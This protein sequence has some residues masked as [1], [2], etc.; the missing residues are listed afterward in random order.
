MQ[1]HLN[2]VLLTTVFT[3][4]LEPHWPSAAISA[5]GKPLTIS[6][7]NDDHPVDELSVTQRHALLEWRRQ[8]ALAERE[9][10]FSD[11]VPPIHP[12]TWSGLTLML[13][14]AALAWSSSEW[15]WYKLIE[16]IRPRRRL[17]ELG[18]VSLAE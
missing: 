18:N 6:P 10:E 8:K 4:A 17:L 12:L 15:E 2:L 11:A 9:F 7:V 1:F 5:T 16:A 14:A 13:L 3:L